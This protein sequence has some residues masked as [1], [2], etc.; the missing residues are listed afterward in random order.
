MDELESV[1]RVI[2]VRL[3]ERQAPLLPSQAAVTQLASVLDVGKP[4]DHLLQPTKRVEAKMSEPGMPQPRLFR[5]LCS[6]ADGLLHLQVKQ[7]Q[8]VLRPLL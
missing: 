4:S 1:R 3:W 5:V 8:L 6:E 7:V 2:L